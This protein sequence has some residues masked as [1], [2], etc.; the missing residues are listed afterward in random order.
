MATTT[1]TTTAT[2]FCGYRGISRSARA[3]LTRERG[4]VNPLSVAKALNRKELKKPD[5][6]V[7]F[8]T[9]LGRK[10][11]EHRKKAITLTVVAVV[12]FAVGWGVTAHRAAQAAKATVAFARIE[13]IASADLLPEKADPKDPAGQAESDG[14][15]RFKTHKERLEAAIKEA[16]AFVAAFGRDGLGRKALLGKAARLLALGQYADAASLYETLAASETDAELRAVEQEGVA[17]AAEARDQL[18]EAL[19]GYTALADMSQRLSGNFYL[20][21]ALFAKARILAKQGKGKEAEEVLRE[22]LTKV[23]KT[24]LRQ[25]IDDRLA[26]LAEK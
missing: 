19:R 7:S 17:A 13:R 22:I 10:L 14:V 20:D 25:Q 4:S 26:V 6:F 8:W 3:A 24:L 9:R 23:P 18:D 2:T 16:D 21:R 1:A 15:P 5:E 12:A 11:T